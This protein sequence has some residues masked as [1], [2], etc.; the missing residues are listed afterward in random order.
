MTTHNI[1]EE[2][3]L[4]ATGASGIFSRRGRIKYFVLITLNIGIQNYFSKNRGAVIDLA[5][6]WDV[7]RYI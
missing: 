2:K 6:F 5:F 4:G 7:F 1:Y 3:N